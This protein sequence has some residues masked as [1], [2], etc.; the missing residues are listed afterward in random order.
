MNVR[1]SF[2]A[3]V[4]T[5]IIVSTVI[6]G[7]LQLF[8]THQSRQQV[9]ALD[10]KIHILNNQNQQLHQQIH[11]IEQ[12]AIANARQQALT[13]AHVKST[14]SVN[15]A[16]K[17]G[18]PVTLV[19]YPGMSISEIALVLTRAGVV[20]ASAPFVIAAIRYNHLLRAGKYTFH[21]NEPFLQ[22]LHTLAIR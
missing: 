10:K 9:F 14:K 7:A 20:P 17:N 12:T 2:Y 16:I 5:G 6:L 18:R 13:V 11:V 22:I 19:I 3:G 4:G 1:P 8:A 15:H 21:V